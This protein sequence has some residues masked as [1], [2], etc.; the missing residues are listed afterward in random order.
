MHDEIPSEYL[1]P[2]TLFAGLYYRVA[3]YGMSTED[4]DRVVE[5]NLDNLPSAMN[6]DW[7]AMGMNPDAGR[8]VAVALHVARR[9]DMAVGPIREVT[10]EDTSLSW[11]E[12]G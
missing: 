10:D 6:E 8:G 2:A 7:E 12:L 5:K 3:R 1:L 4:F 9:L 11:I